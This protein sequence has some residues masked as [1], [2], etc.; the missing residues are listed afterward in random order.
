MVDAFA[1]VSMY[2][3]HDMIKHPFERECG[4]GET[5]ITNG[6]LLWIDW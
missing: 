1:E 4:V 3:S 5:D 2:I 6:L